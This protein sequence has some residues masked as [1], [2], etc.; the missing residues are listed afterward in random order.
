MVKIQR[1]N[2]KR[3]MRTTADRAV[4]KG[5]YTVDSDVK[6][7]YYFI[8][9]GQIVISTAMGY[10]RMELDDA[11]LMAMELIDLT[12]AHRKDLRVGRKC[13]GPRRIKELM[14]PDWRMP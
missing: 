14:E 6:G 2:T 4:S 12:E 3:N 9:D 10:V 8:E 11:E 13:I 1:Y 5:V 7:L